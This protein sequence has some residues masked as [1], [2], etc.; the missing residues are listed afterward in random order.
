MWLI[1]NHDVQAPLSFSCRLDVYWFKSM[2]RISPWLLPQNNRLLCL[3]W[4]ARCVRWTNIESDVLEARHDV[5]NNH[6]Q[7]TFSPSLQSHYTSRNSSIVS[8]L[9][10]LVRKFPFNSHSQCQRYLKRLC[11]CLYSIP[12]SSVYVCYLSWFKT[13]L[14]FLA[15]NSGYNFRCPISL[16]T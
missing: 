16:V 14:I 8:W 15:D 10:K 6:D 9:V 2:G 13:P 12:L 1:T 4:T 7:V 3:K 11:A 5:G